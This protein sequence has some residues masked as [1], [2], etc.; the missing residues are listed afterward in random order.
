MIP[1]N[2]GILSS[3]ASSTSS[4]SILSGLLAYWKLDETSGNAA[5]STGTYTGTSGNITYDATGKLGRCY[6]FN[7]TSSDVSLGNVIKPTN[8]MSAACWFKASSSTNNFPI[9]D[10]HTYGTN[11]EGYNFQMY[12]DSAVG[13]FF[14]SNTA[15][16]E[17][18][19]SNPNYPTTYFD[20]NWH[21]L[22]FTWDGTT[23]YVYIDGTKDAGTAYNTIFGQG[24]LDEV[25]IWNRALTTTEVATLYNSGAGKTYPF[26]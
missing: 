5:D 21:H 2:Y 8:A 23:L 7:G 26:S 11:Y 20:N 9:L 6:D 17:D 4:S 19:S 12:T 15:T 10:C 16:M 18:Y 22:A 24:S 1:T 14:G 13:V 25:G 3:K